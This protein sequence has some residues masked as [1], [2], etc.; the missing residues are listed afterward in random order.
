MDS[1]GKT[2]T[3][4]LKTKNFLEAVRFMNKTAEVA[5]E[6]NHHP[7]LHLENFRQLTIVL[8]THALGGL[9]QNDF[10]LAAKINEIPVQLYKVK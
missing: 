7:D 6:E 2:I 1:K 9:S 5:E 8:S 4:R 10:I 3:R